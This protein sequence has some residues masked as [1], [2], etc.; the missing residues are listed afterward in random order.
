MNKVICRLRGR[1]LENFLI[2][3]NNGLN[4]KILE[5]TKGL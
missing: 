2:K 5:K 1:E 3:K 4:F